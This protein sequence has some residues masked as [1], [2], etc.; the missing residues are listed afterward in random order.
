M[1]TA[2]PLSVLLS[3]PLDNA[4]CLF[5]LKSLQDYHS[6]DTRYIRLLCELRL[7]RFENATKAINEIDS[8]N[9]SD[10]L[11]TRLR[12]L[13]RDAS[14]VDSDSEIETNCMH[15]ALPSWKSNSISPDVIADALNYHGNLARLVHE[16][17][18][19]IDPVIRGCAVWKMLRDG[20]PGD[21][22]QLCWQSPVYNHDLLCI[23]PRQ[24]EPEL[25]LASLAVAE[26]QV[27]SGKTDNL[28]QSVSLAYK[29]IASLG[30]A[31]GQSAALEL[32]HCS[33]VRSFYSAIG[34]S[35]PLHAHLYSERLTD[36]D[37]LWS[38]YLLTAARIEQPEDEVDRNWK[39]LLNEFDQWTRRAGLRGVGNQ[40]NERFANAMSVFDSVFRCPRLRVIVLGETSAGKSALLNSI[41]GMEVLPSGRTETTGVPTILRMTQNRVPCRV[42]VYGKNDSV[43]EEKEFSREPGDLR[44]VRDLIYRRVAVDSSQRIGVDRIVVEVSG[45]D[46][47]MSE[48]IE[49]VDAPGLNA[50]AERTKIVEDAV[51]RSHACI[52]VLDGRNAMKAGEFKSLKWTDEVLSRTLFVVNKVDLLESDDELDVDSS[53]L[54][55]VQQRVRD[56]LSSA[57]GGGDSSIVLPASAATRE[58]IED[59]LKSLER[60]LIERGEHAVVYAASRAARSVAKSAV[61]YVF[62]KTTDSERELNALWGN[63]PA[64][65]SVFEVTLKAQVR[66]SWGAA[67]EKFIERMSDSI[68]RAFI[69]FNGKVEQRIGAYAQRGLEGLADFARRELRPLLDDFVQRVGRARDDAWINLGH[70]TT[71]DAVEY[72]RAI[73][74]EIDFPQGFHSDQMLE[75]ATPMPLQRRMDGVL[76]SIDDK[77]SG[78]ATSAMMGV[79]MAA[80]I[81]QLVGGGWGA[82][83]GGAIAALGANEQFEKAKT[84]VC[85]LIDGQIQICI[86]ELANAIQC[87]V[88]SKSSNSDAPMLEGILKALDEQRNACEQMVME[89]IREVEDRIKSIE[90][91]LFEVRENAAVAAHWSRRFAVLSKQLRS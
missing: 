16:V 17:M 55:T 31:Y 61:E 43:L 28:T 56:V 2:F 79:G 27:L 60:M 6:S 3:L 83:I 22:R 47:K 64:S 12:T 41:L 4:A 20:R 85:G 49:L 1:L 5:I 15:D 89:K 67:R 7:R 30:Q 76:T 72:F 38:S 71:A 91:D 63:L 26:V 45:T 40:S 77:V 52:F 73:Y 19:R 10:P 88:D 42:Q 33:T 34:D 66:R 78:F 18:V 75:S 9:C 8:S 70:Q 25:W 23:S 87:D 32:R 54:A 53:P 68:K 90:E 11:I 21:A 35:K 48:E 84:E 58:G 29:I 81:G 69:E 62:S 24:R 86:E 82:L 46:H 80:G 51:A 74:E 36:E 44:A 39:N 14:G 57:V 65:P 59:I 50:H 37:V 13:L